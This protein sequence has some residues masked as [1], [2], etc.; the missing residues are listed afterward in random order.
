[1]PLSL[2][3]HVLLPLLLVCGF[4]GSVLLAWRLLAA[5]DFLYP[6]WYEVIGID[7]TIAE[8]GPKNRY[9]HH[10][11]AT[12]KAER[13]RL[14]AAISDG[15]LHE[16]RGL[17]TLR[18]RLPDGTPIDT[19]LRKPEIVH[20]RSVANLAAWLERAGWIALG[21]ALALGIVT[22]KQG[23]KL[24]S[25]GRSLGGT[26][27]LLALGVVAVL[28]FGP[29]KVFYDLHV[30]FFPSD[31]QWFFYYQESLMTMLMKA[32]VLFGYVAAALVIVALV[33]F[34]A[35]LAT[36]RL[37]ARFFVSGHGNQR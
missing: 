5:A 34:I 6:V 25:L 15:V 13:V 8:Y 29:E 9:K 7:A 30:R 28:L 4:L 22:V 26:F 16:G 33:L 32:P 14:F 37:C 1:M 27:G 17:E 3:R 2:Q 23:A 31:Q 35:L 18:Y 10:F 24:P 11:E 19:L 21:I 36:H 12:D 20:L